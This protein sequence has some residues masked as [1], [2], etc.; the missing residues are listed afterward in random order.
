MASFEFASV[1][2]RNGADSTWIYV[3]S[4]GKRRKKT[5]LCVVARAGQR[6]RRCDLRQF[7]VRLTETLGNFTPDGR[8]AELWQ[9]VEGGNRWAFRHLT[10]NPSPRSRRRG[11][12]YAGRASRRKVAATAASSRDLKVA[13][14][15]TPFCLAIFCSTGSVQFS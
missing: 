5:R 8:A 1:R 13:R 11:I 4:T 9:R 10:L 12:F 2:R 7:T 6:K 3:V 14:L 15:L